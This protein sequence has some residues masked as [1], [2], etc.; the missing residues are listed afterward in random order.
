MDHQ[1][2]RSTS[3]L[4]PSR[5]ANGYVTSQE[6]KVLPLA[7]FREASERRLYQ[8]IKSALTGTDKGDVT[9]HVNPYPA[10]FSSP[11]PSPSQSSLKRNGGNRDCIS[12]FIYVVYM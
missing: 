10:P 4:S 5:D 1:S 11:S 6:T 9:G 3:P 2:D 7:S 12:A 8:N